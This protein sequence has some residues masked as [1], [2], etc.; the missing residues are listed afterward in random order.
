MY[1]DEGI[2][3]TCITFRKAF[4][5]MLEDAKLGKFDIIYVKS[6]SRFARNTVDG[7]KTCEE[8]RAI[9]VG[10][11]FEDCGLNSIDPENDMTLAV[12]FSVAQ[13][14]SQTKS[15]NVKWGIRQRQKAGKWFCNAHFGYDKIERG[16]IINEQEAAVKA[17]A[18]SRPDA[19]IV[20]GAWN[21]IGPDG[22][23]QRAMKA[24]PYSLNMHIWYGTYLASTALFLRR[25]TTIEEGFLL[26]ERF[27]YDMD[28]E[29][30]A[31]LGRAGKKFVHYNR[32]LADFRWHG[33]NLSAPNIERRDMDAELKR[34]KQHGEDAAIK[35]IYGYSFSKHSCNNIM[36]GF[37]REAYRMKKAFLYL[38]TPWEK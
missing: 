16:L 24:L 29:Y 37:M 19:D 34:Q 3:G 36:D 25:S 13:K 1:I 20:H 8:L 6:V 2:S 28:G 22:D 21:F 18:D 11:F 12:L 31:R 4:E 35:R 14:E 38:T 15:H 10:V 33:D 32:L 27:H 5:K 7:L 26:D 17:F 30:Y 23:I 9:G